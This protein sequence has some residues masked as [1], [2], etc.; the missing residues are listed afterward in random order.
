MKHVFIINPTSGRK[1]KRKKLVTNI[2]LAAKKLGVDCEIY[3]TRFS[4]DGEE[5]LQNLCREHCSSNAARLADGKK[6]ETLRVYG[7]GGDGTLNEMVNGAFGFDNIEIGIIPTGTGNDYVRNYGR[8]ADFHNIENQILGKSRHS[9]LIK[10]RAEYNDRIT[11]GYCANM[12]NIGLDCNAVDMTETTKTWPLL[13]GH[14]AYLAA[15]GIVFIKKKCTDLHIE[16]EDGRIK[17]GPI[18]L[19]AIA[20]GCFCGGGVK[21]VPESILDDGL[22]D[23]SVV[24]DI[25]RRRFLSLY[26]SYTKGTHLQKSAVIKE[27]L[28]EYTKEKTLTVTANGESMRFCCDG[29]ITTQKKVSFSMVEDAF[30]F[31]VPAG[32]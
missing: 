14:L 4:G 12:F 29:E 21:G 8:V 10:Y 2:N 16:Y 15:V 11:I 26:P 31:V 20:N 13:H 32:L 18:L 1:S 28:I 25:S 7:C 9:D 23:V 3:F 5:Y 24:N 30:L 17:D 6:P 22:M 19:I 27:N